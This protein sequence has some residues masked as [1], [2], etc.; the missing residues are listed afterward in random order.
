MKI[1]VI[2]GASSGVGKAAALRF[3]A[4]GYQ[5]CGLSRNIEKLDALEQEKVW[6]NPSISN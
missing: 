6:E 5:V 4:E 2:T 3:S 1:M